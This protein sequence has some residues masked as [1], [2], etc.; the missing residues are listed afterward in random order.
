MKRRSLFLT[1]CL[2]L[3]GPALARADVINFSGLSTDNPITP[4][5]PPEAVIP[6]GYA[7]FN[8]S[9][10]S[11]LNTQ[12]DPN[13]TPSGYSHAN[14]D[15][16]SASVAFNLYGKPASISR[17]TPFSFY[18]A[19]FTAAWKDDLHV[20]VKGYRNGQ[21]LYDKHFTVDSTGPTFE[22][23]DFLN[24]DTLDFKSYAGHDTTVH[25]WV[26][27]KPR[28][29]PPG[30]QFALDDLVYIPAAGGASLDAF[31][32]GGLASPAPEPAGFVLFAVGAAAAGVFAWRRRV[33]A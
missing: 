10:F 29:H 7:G 9:N 3:A 22:A 8:W 5:N 21:L 4:S 18:G 6:N 19:F 14:T 28:S 27:G 15:S 20:D 26:P 13:A 2:L 16:A 24:V 12:N 23:F 17:A 33:L 1:A 32:Q 31:V 30:N 25:G 11:S